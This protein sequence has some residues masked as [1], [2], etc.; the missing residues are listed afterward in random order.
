MKNLCRDASVPLQEGAVVVPR[1]AIAVFMLIAKSKDPGPV[2][3]ELV[4][5]LRVDGTASFVV[6]KLLGIGRR[7]SE[8]ENRLTRDAE[9][10]RPLD[11]DILSQIVWSKAKR[12]KRLTGR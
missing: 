11:S 4:V 3:E 7:R 1:N 10:I 6:G 5:G 2:F 8:I 12:I 9:A